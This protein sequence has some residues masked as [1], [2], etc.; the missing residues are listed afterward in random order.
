MERYLVYTTDEIAKRAIDPT[1]VFAVP[2]P[3]SP[4]SEAPVEKVGLIHIYETE[5]RP[6][7]RLRRTRRAAAGRVSR[8]DVAAVSSRNLKGLGTVPLVLTAAAAPAT[9]AAA[10]PATTATTATTE[11]M[12]TTATA[13]TATAT[14]ATAAPSHLLKAG[15]AV[16]LIE[17][18]ERGETDVSHLLLVKNEAMLVVVRLRDISGRQRR[19]GCASR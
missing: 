11:M 14:M 17:Q 6:A 1:R 13:T 8:D 7:R 12:A 4:S 18:M 3:Q 9:P 2:Q 10:A 15:G 16:L 5:P 19:C